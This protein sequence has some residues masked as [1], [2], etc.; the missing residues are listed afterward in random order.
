MKAVKNY[1]DFKENLL[2]K[3]IRKLIHITY[4]YNL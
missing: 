1:W 3:R 4:K 2:I